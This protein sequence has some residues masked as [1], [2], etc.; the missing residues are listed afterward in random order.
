MLFRLVSP[1]AASQARIGSTHSFLFRVKFRGPNGPLS[2][3]PHANPLNLCRYFE[4]IYSPWI[5][6]LRSPL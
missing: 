6:S 3:M 5:L 4:A 1:R 2:A